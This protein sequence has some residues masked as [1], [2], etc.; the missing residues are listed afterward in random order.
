MTDASELGFFIVNVILLPVIINRLLAN[1]S[2]VT[3]LLLFLQCNQILE[4]VISIEQI[5]Y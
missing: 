2:F 3:F 5:E 1:R 4:T